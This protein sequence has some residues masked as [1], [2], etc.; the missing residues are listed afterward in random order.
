MLGMPDGDIAAP[1]G[2]PV[3]LLRVLPPYRTADCLA[4]RKAVADRARYL[5]RQHE[6]RA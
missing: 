2:H 5:R 1:M 3:G 6:T 4:A